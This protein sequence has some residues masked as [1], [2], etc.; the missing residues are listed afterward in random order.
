MR[1][2][3]DMIIGARIVDVHLTTAI[4]NG[5]DCVVHYFTCDRGFTFTMPF[6]GKAWETEVVPKE[7]QRQD[8]KVTVESYA[9]KK[10]WLGGQRFVRETPR[11]DDTIFRLKRSEIVGVFCGSFNS[12]MGLY[13]PPEATL[14][15]SDGF[16]LICNS[17]APHGTGAAGLYYRSPD[18]DLPPITEMVDFFTIP[19]SGQT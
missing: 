1:I 2:T 7:A 19:V 6:A 15:M 3:R 18:S 17:V 4:T 11:I 16:C 9:M 5:L 8:D 13:D 14:V 10:T 12:E